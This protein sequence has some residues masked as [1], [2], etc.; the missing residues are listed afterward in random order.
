MIVHG[1]VAWLLVA[2]YVG[3]VAWVQGSVEAAVTIICYARHWAGWCWYNA[4]TCMSGLRAVTWC[5]AYR[6]VMWAVM[7]MRRAWAG[8][9][10]FQNM[11]ELLCVGC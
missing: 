2:L 6:H 4:W 1:M 10:G 9:Q 11:M 5:A 8:G 7:L 3:L